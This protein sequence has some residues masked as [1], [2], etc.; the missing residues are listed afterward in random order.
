[1]KRILFVMLL[2]F[3]VQ[4]VGFTQFKSQPEVRSAVGSTLVRT[5]AGDL[6]S[7]WFDPSRLSFHN[8]YSL[9]YVTSGSYGLSLGALTSSIGYQLSD[10][11]SVR[12][13]VSLTH[14][15]YSTLG[16]N[17]TNSLTG[18]HLTR[19]ELNYRPSKNTLIQ[20]QY[21]QLP[22]MY[23]MTGYDVMGFGSGF[24]GQDEEELH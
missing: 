22:A 11:L 14:S 7:G 21:R 4:S 15:P 20:L 18:V 8:S 23:W 12:F 5:D 3:V 6:L 16:N 13:D 24:L 9:S 10:P 17:F 19:A 2:I 1:M